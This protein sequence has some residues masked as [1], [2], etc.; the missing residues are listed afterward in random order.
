MTVLGRGDLSPP[1]RHRP[2]GRRGHPGLRAF[3]VLVLL[4]SLVAGGWWGWRHLRPPDSVR[5]RSAPASCVTPSALGTP[6]RVAG[7]RMRVLNGS[8]RSGLAARV[9]R[10]LHGRFGVVVTRVGNAPRFLRGTSV[11]RYPPAQVA[12]AR[13]AAV[14]VLPRAR[15]AATNRVARIELDLG[16]GFRAVAAYGGSRRV[17]AAS[18]AP[19]AAARPCTSP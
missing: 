10:Q 1:R 12:Q 16:T 15:L 9:A 3:L 8:L 17:G 11:L 14:L 18:P 4:A 6:A 19:S 7:V 5:T 2:G 13:L